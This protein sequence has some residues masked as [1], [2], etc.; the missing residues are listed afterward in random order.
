MVMTIEEDEDDDFDDDVKND[1]QLSRPATLNSRSR[2]AYPQTF[3]PMTSLFDQQS[4][5]DF[6]L[7]KLNLMKLNPTKLN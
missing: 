7:I 6:K 1:M 2:L 5:N 4:D 3:W